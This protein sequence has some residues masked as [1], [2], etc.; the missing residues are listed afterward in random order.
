MLIFQRENV[1]ATR[2]AGGLWGVWTYTDA[3][4][5]AL[6]GYGTYGNIDWGIGGSTYFSVNGYSDYIT[7]KA[8]GWIYCDAN[9]V[10]YFRGYVDDGM[11]LIID[12]ELLIDYPDRSGSEAYLP[13]SD[14][15]ATSL[16]EGF[17]EMLLFY[18]QG[19]GDNGFRL[20]WKKGDGTWEI[21]PGDVLYHSADVPNVW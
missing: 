14:G 9:D 7:F 8:A 13:S 5:D 16:T 17:H 2:Y 18:R 10:Y 12:G 6:V 1:P 11:T 3:Y 4:E 19:S 20:E 21:I 15:A